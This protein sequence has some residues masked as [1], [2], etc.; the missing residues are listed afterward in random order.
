M[1]INNIVVHKI[2]KTET[3][4]RPRIDFSAEELSAEN[5]VVE[6][7]AKALSKTYFEKK[8]RFYTVYKIEEDIEP[9]FKQKTDEY[10]DHHE[11]YRYTRQ[12]T[13][14]LYEKMDDTPSSRGGFVVT[15]DY[16]SSNNNRYLFIA[17]LNNKEDFSISDSLEI[18]KNLTL[19]IDK[20]AMASV[21]NISRY[22]EGQDNYITFLRGLREIPD[23]FISFIGANKDRKKDIREVTKSWR[24]AIEQFYESE[25]ISQESI[26]ARTKSIITQIK[27][28]NRIEELIT[29]EV[30]A[31][32]IYPENPERFIGFAFNEES[33]FELHSE[34]DRL[35]TQILNDLSAVNYV[36]KSKGFGLKFKRKDIGTLI[37]FDMDNHTI[38]IDDQE[39]ISAIQREMEHADIQ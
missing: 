33:T 10:L 4:R 14:I 28:L 13:E 24:D 12:V 21:L 9:A 38:V 18:V 32:I 8:S 15:M 27:N 37:N 6:E 39:I 35:D 20:M 3:Q 23:Y 30:L 34:M 1:I 11:F 36:N 22:L 29:A 26:D 19:N 2:I 25:E 7:F 16:S 5:S 17:L 31:N